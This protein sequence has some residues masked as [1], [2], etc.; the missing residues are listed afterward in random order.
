MDGLGDAQSSGLIDAQVRTLIARHYRDEIDACRKLL[1]FA[2]SELVGWSGRPARR[3]ADRIIAAEVARA[4][5]TFDAVIG[6]CRR[7]YGEQAIMLDRSL[8][9]GMAVAHWVSDNR[10]E[11]VKLFNR[12][13]KFTAVLEAEAWTKEFGALPEGP[14]ASLGPKARAEC[15]ALFGQYGAWPWYRR[16]NLP[17]LLKDIEH[18]WDEE[19]RRQLWLFYE[20]PLVFSNQILH[21]TAIAVDAAMTGATRDALSYTVGP[22]NQFIGRALFFSYWIYGQIF[23]LMID[24]FRLKCRPEFDALWDPGGAVFANPD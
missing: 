24:V 8:F 12:H 2:V 3:G 10:R 9:E 18:L 17:L 7:G 6:L 13:A 22:S 23:G 15:V 5:K 19:G 14:R 16:R 11:A 21:S 20:I 1:D 4:T